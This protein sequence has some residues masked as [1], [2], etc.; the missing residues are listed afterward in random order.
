MEPVTV[1]IENLEVNGANGDDDV[2]TPWS[3]ESKNDAGVDYDKLISNY[4]ITKK[5]NFH[6]LLYLINHC[7]IFQS[8]LAAQKLTLNYWNASK[9]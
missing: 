4:Y 6:N 5:K 2:V 1:G 7:L 9:K 3:V 8:V